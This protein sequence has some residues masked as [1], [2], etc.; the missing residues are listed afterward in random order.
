MVSTTRY[1]MCMSYAATA[2]VCSHEYT[3]WSL[4]VSGRERETVS[5]KGEGG[6]RERERERECVCE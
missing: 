4:T 6:G 2:R 3:V 1:C 5:E